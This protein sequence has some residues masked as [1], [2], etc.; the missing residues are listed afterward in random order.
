MPRVTE[1]A[2]ICTTAFSVVLWCSMWLIWCIAVVAMSV[3]VGRANDDG[4]CPPCASMQ[5]RQLPPD[6]ARPAM[7]GENAAH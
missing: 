3:D 2:I 6:T 1:D 7:G 4:G 5:A